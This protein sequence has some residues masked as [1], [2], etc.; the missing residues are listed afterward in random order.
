MS[1]TWQAITSAVVVLAVVAAA[2]VL[3]AV[4]TL[5]ATYAGTIISG[6]LGYA[7]H[8]SGVVIGSN[9]TTTTTVT[10]RSVTTRAGQ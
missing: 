1:S 4:G 8:A 9:A 5:S 10:P 3:A 6:A 2:S 7:I